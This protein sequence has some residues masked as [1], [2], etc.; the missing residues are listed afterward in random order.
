MLRFIKEKQELQNYTEI[1]FNSLE[2]GG[3]GGVTT[4][5]IQSLVHD[6]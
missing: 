5:Y 4:I 6:Q 3:G 1:H 2:L